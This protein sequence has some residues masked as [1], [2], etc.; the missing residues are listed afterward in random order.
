MGNPVIH[1]EVSGSD[2]AKLQK[3]Y[4]D[5]FD[6]K[7]NADN[8]MNYGIVDNGG[9]GINGGVG[10]SPNG[11]HLTWYVQVPH[12]CSSEEG[13]RYGRQ[14]GDAAN[15]DGHGHLRAVGRSR[16]QR[17]RPRRRKLANTVCGCSYRAPAYWLVRLASPGRS[18]RGFSPTSARRS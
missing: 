8:P 9:E 14:D 17:R 3:F 12:R 6:W 10:Q 18:A 1:F 4:G 16:G 11:P 7:I 13:R 5:L 15:R 2:G